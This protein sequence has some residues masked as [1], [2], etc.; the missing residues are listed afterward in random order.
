MITSKPLSATAIRCLQHASTDGIDRDPKI[1]KAQLGVS[2]IVSDLSIGLLRKKDFLTDD[3]KITE[4]GVRALAEAEAE[5][6]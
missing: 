4:A 5:H 2:G 3:W 6:A 1:R